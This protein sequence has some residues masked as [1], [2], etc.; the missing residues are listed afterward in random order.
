V[1]GWRASCGR[2]TPRKRLSRP[3]MPLTAR[4]DAPDLGN[5]GATWAT[6]V[7]YPPTYLS[8]GRRGL[9]GP[10]GLSR[11]VENPRFVAKFTCKNFGSGC[12]ILSHVRSVRSDGSV[13]E[14]DLYLVRMAWQGSQSQSQ[15]KSLVSWFRSLAWFAS[16]LNTAAMPHEEVGRSHQVKSQAVPISARQG[17]GWTAIGRHSLIP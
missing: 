2:K 10:K 3:A 6:V 15:S 16:P 14:E 17:Q 4:I 7:L 12:C 11:Q 8:D 13:E 9:P 1:R 5:A